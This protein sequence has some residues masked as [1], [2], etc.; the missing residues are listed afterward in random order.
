MR[1]AHVTATFPPYRGGT[2]NVCFENAREL[3]R[4]G[5]ATSV[6]TAA[7]AGARAR[8]RRDGIAVHRLRPA[9]RFGNASLLPGLLPALRGFDLIH[10]HYPFFGGEMVL[11]AARAGRAPL[12]ITYHQDVVLDGLAGVAEHILRQTAGRLLL[13][14]ATRVLFTSLDYAGA[15]Y[16][17]PLLADRPGAIGELP[18]GVDTRRFEPGQAPA[19]LRTRHGLATGDRVALLV[20]GLDRAH[21]FKGVPVFLEA[22]ARLPESVK[23][24]VVGDGELRAKYAAR[25]AELGIGGRAIF[26]GRVSEAELPGYYRLA[27]VT[28]L[29]SLTMGEAFGLTLLESLACAT[30]VIASRLPGVRT[31][32]DHNGDGLLVEPGRPDLL[33][34]ALR[35]MVEHEPERR[36]M[37]QRGRH[38]A[39]E[40]YSWSCIGDRLE[41]VYDEVLYQRM[42]VGSQQ[43][44]VNSR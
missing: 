16:I 32:V 5:H 41:A 14:A 18:N 31:V 33:A 6:F 15:S 40:R 8:E 19:E 25:A 35:W 10:L 38:K 17:R 21:Y 27:D 3:A 7:V 30:P 37:G 34:D 43:A 12:V 9:A 44:T 36:A 42:A 13:H 4:R 22:L 29:P 28:V 2:G 20:A 23:G 26:A 11:L 39:Q 1:I 24:I